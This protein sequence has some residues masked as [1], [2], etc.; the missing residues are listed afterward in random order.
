MYIFAVKY[1]VRSCAEASLSDKG[2]LFSEKQF[3][4]M[5]DTNASQET[6]KMDSINMKTFSNLYDYYRKGTHCDVV[7]ISEQDGT[8]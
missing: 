8:R 5:R 4:K 1:I 2:L 3:V 6:N 7:L